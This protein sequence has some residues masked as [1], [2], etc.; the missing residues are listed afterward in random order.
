VVYI[1]V[2]ARY[3]LC[4]ATHFATARKHRRAIDRKLAMSSRELHL[5]VDLLHSGVYASAWRLPESDPGHFSTSVITCA[6][7][8]LP[9]AAS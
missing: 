2:V 4:S 1:I 7:P 5:N 3:F 8:A 9:S 6:S